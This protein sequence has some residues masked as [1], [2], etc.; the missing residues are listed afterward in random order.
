M[1]VWPVTLS[2]HPG[3]LSEEALRSM[4]EDV[5]GSSG[6]TVDGMLHA[7]S[8]GELPIFVVWENVPEILLEKHREN[9]MYLLR[10][11]QMQGMMSCYATLESIKFGIPD[12]RE[13]CWGT[14]AFGPAVDRSKE[15]CVELCESIMNK[16]RSMM[17]VEPLPLQ[18]F[19]LRADDVYIA[20]QLIKLKATKAA[21]LEKPMQ[22]TQWGKDLQDACKAVC[23][24]VSSL[25]LPPCLVGNETFASLNCREQK[26]V[27]LQLRVDPTVTS[28]DMHPSISR[29]V[30]GTNGILNTVT[31]GSKILLLPPV[32][33]VARMM[34]GLEELSTVGFPAKVLKRFAEQCNIVDA[35]ILMGDLAGNAMSGPVTLAF[36]VAILLEVSDTMVAYLGHREASGVISN[37]GWKSDDENVAAMILGGPGEVYSS[38]GDESAPSSPSSGASGAS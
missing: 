23:V 26:G 12:L 24:P 32:V 2:A 20:K 14:C 36:L 19:L 6:E 9:L 38:S 34:T 5:K 35:D 33:P 25:K 37:K 1:L 13:R 11:W 15:G 7:F 27:L 30:A 22:E 4:L 3:D 10:Q 29:M 17:V 16:V 18:D 31:P 21:G 28:I 8:R